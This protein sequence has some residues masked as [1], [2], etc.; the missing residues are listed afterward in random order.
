MAMGHEYDRFNGWKA[1]S[2][3][4]GSMFMQ[5]LQDHQS[6]NMWPIEKLSPCELAALPHSTHNGRLVLCK[7]MSNF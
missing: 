5:R 7:H 2:S 3:A 1:M 4:L 6:S